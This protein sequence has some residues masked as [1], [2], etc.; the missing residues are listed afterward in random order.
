MLRPPGEAHSREVDIHP[1][2][3]KVC[4]GQFQ[5]ICPKKS[6]DARPPRARVR[7]VIEVPSGGRSGASV[8]RLSMP[9]G[10]EQ[11]PDAPFGLVDPVL[12]QACARYIAMR[13][14]QPMR[15]MR[16]FSPSRLGRS[17]TAPSA[18]LGRLG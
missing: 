1:A 13:V 8:G 7:T 18:A 4:G 6:N 16:L 12:E 10:L 15:Q 9:A 2:V 11:E 5:V 3:R 17:T 14:A